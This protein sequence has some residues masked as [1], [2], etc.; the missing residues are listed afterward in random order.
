MI[1]R[2]IWL[3][4]MHLGTRGCNAEHIL[5]FLKENDAETIYLVGDIV[6]GWRLSRKFYWPQSHNDVVQKLLRKVRKGVRMIY[7]PGNHDEFLRP[8]AGN[9]MGGIEIVNEAIHKTADGR[10]LLI[11]HGDRFDGVVTYHKWLA[12]LGDW[13]YV[14]LLAV[15]RWYGRIRR[16]F[17]YGHW[18]LSAFLKHKVKK[19]VSFISNYET[20]IAHECRQRGFDGIVCG[21]IHHAEIKTI[22]GILYC[23]S[24]DFVESCSA[25][26]EDFDGKISIVHW[27]SIS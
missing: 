21:H 4:D 14:T 13:A 6:D 24:G 23:N 1:Y 26:V 22:D 5:D 25:L 19:A 11:I 16:R 10:R 8:Y 17:G 2:T 20:A 18:S 12:I 7:I 9:K 15:N 27:H 3:S